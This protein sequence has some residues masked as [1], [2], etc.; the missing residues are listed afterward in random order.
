MPTLPNESIP[1]FLE[2][3]NSFDT[4]VSCIDIEMLIKIHYV[5]NSFRMFRFF[6]S[7]PF[8]S[9]DI[10]QQQ[11]IPPPPPGSPPLHL[12]QPKLKDPDKFILNRVLYFHYDPRFNKMIVTET[13]P[14]L[15][16]MMM[17]QPPPILK[18]NHIMAPMEPAQPPQPPFMYKSNNIRHHNDIKLSKS[19]TSSSKT[20][21]SSSHKSLHPSNETNLIVLSSSPSNA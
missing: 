6:F 21:H 4:K 3:E 12:P 14:H 5:W 1:L 16:P 19:K 2:K 17:A 9:R 8:Q 7:C 15:M 18:T 20:Y 11:I 13:P 10:E